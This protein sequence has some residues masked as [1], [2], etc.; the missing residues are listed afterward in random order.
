MTLVPTASEA[1][2]VTFM[3]RRAGVTLFPLVVYVL[4]STLSTDADC[5]GPFCALYVYKRV[6]DSL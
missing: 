4:I 2:T 6:A 5:E 3:V 1:E